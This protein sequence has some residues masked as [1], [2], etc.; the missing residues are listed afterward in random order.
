MTELEQKLGHAFKNPKLLKTALTHSSF[1]NESKGKKEVCNERLE[2]LGDSILGF[3]VAKYLY[4]NRPDMPE[5]KMTKLRAE[6]VCEQSLVQIAD[7]LEL[8]TH[9]FLGKGEELGGGRERP[10]ILADAVEALFAAIFLDSGIRKAEQVVL[11]L[12]D[13][14]LTL[15][16]GGGA[17]Q[18]YKTALQELVQRKSGQSLSYHLLSAIGPDHQKVFEVEVQ[19]N[20]TSVGTGSGKSKKE[21]EQIAASM[22][23][24]QMRER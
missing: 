1:A 20:G 4:K 14:N 7:K 2:F 22:A 8:G 17:I 23:I 11:S 13:E 15:E 19:L 16:Q 21:A 10:S 6:L 24:R 3:T 18:D 9:L 12:L 5:G